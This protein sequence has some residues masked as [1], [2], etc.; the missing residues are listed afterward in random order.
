MTDSLDLREV[1]VGYGDRP[2]LE[3]VSLSIPHGAQAAVIG[4]NGAGKSA[5]FKALVGLLPLQGGTMLVHGRPPAEY[6]EPVAYVPQ[7]EEVD[8][9]FP[10]TVQDVVSMGRYGR[11]RWM[12]KLSGRDRNIVDQSLVRLG[13]AELAKRPI[14]DLSGGQQQRV[15]LARALAQEPHILLL[16]EPFTGVDIATREAIFALLSDLRDR[17]VT[18]LLSTHDLD[19]ASERFDLVVLLNRRLVSVGAPEEVFTAQNLQEAFGGQMVFV[20]GKAIV[21]D[22]CCGGHGPVGAVD[23][24]RCDSCDE[25]GLPENERRP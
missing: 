3:A 15:F 21:V 13:I 16:D 12:R 20:N 2:A 24:C 5:L 25:A 8:W 6:R 22:Q 1:S 11:G 9:R 4:P 14:G 19:L 18:V 10:V 7:R 17:S 23:S